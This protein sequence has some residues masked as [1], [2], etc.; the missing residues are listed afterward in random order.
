MH[1]YRAPTLGDYGETRK[2]HK[3]IKPTIDI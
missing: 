2:E 3:P 1:T